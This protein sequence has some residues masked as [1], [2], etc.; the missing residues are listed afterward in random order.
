MNQINHEHTE[1]AK[2]GVKNY[3]IGFVLA[4]VLT[5][6]SFGLTQMQSLSR[7]QM[8]ICIFI[9][10]VVQMLV[11]LRFFL[12]MDRS[13]GSRWNLIFLAFTAVLIFLFV[14]GTIWVMFTL[15]SRMM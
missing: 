11:H 15:N 1:V 8:I 3:L 7:R 2:S 6:I 4:L 13:S 14:G 9:A 12:H 5:L 10:A